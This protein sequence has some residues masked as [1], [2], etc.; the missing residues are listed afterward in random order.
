MIEKNEFRIC[1]LGY[2]FR[3]Q[4]YFLDPPLYVEGGFTRIRNEIEEMKN[5][6]DIII[7]SIHWG[8]E[9]IEY[10]S[11]AQMDLAHQIID[12]GA[13]IIL[14]HHPH[15]LQGVEKYGE[16]IIAYSLGNFIFDMR[17]ER[18]RKTMILKLVISATGNIDHEIIP[19]MINSRFQPRI[20]G[21][22]DS[23]A[24]TKDISHLCEKIYNQ[25]GGANY[26]IELRKEQK[27]YRREIYWHYLTNLHK[28]NPK[29][30]YSN[31]VGAVKRRLK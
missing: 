5:K 24:I 19:V 29:H 26:D 9:F 15:I 8:D 23:V 17:Q 11:P 28:Y 22:E 1:L 16:G 25:L 31:F 3:P 13:N 7:V 10:P 14:G 21:R 6:A 18:F 12:C 30:A 27:R 4:Q 2:N 20:P